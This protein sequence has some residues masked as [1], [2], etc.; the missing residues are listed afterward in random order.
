MQ[1]LVTG[2]CGFIGSAFCR[3]L[4]AEGHRILN[5]DSLT[6]AASEDAVRSIADHAGYLFKHGD[7]NDG[8]MLGDLLERFQPDAVVN[9]AA[10]THVDRSI[11]DSSS[12]VQTNIVGTHRLLEAVRL[13]WR[14]LPAGK[15][16]DFRFC[17]V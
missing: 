2:G 14:R 10:E 1:V 15:K 16:K 6:Y 7:I 17:H 8:A 9:L 13:Y 12:F 11:D 3:L 5:V 4:I